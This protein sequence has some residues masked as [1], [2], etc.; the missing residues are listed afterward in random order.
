MIG[1]SL[2]HS[3]LLASGMLSM[4]DIVFIFYVCV[5]LCTKCAVVWPCTHVLCSTHACVGHAVDLGLVTCVLLI[6][7]PTSSIH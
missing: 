7:V 2:A 3:V 6:C 4:H 1:Q 5:F